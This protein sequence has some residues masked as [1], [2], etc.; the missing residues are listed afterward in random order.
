MAPIMA[1][2]V[3]ILSPLNT[4]GSDA[5]SRSLANVCQPPAA[6]ERISSRESGS[7]EVRPRYALSS[8]G[9]KVRM[10]TM[11]AFDCQSKPKRTT[12]MG[13]MP[14]IGMELV[15]TAYGITPRAKKVKR[16][17]IMAH[18]KPSPEP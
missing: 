17:A 12:A 8:M 16:D 6:Y 1:S 10:A 14:T 2:V 18:R 13:A 9:K 4:Y 11:K 15:I 7:I 3:L 5:G